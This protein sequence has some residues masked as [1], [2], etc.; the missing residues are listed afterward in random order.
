[1][2]EVPHHPTS[3][4]WAWKLCKGAG[5]DYPSS[6]FCQGHTNTRLK[7]LVKKKR[8]P[9]VAWWD[10]MGWNFSFCF[11]SV[12]C[13]QAKLTVWMWGEAPACICT[14]KD[15]HFSTN[16]RPPGRAFFLNLLS[17]DENN[18]KQINWRVAW[19]L[20]QCLKAWPWWARD[21]LGGYYFTF[22]PLYHQEC[23]RLLYTS[24]NA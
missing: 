12:M 7:T 1:M 18:A 10:A 6:L 13:G 11:A 9:K 4:Q 14:P 22:L 8:V 19:I 5:N 20:H 17:S 16:A 21:S 3:R 15:G 2:T 23:I 24:I